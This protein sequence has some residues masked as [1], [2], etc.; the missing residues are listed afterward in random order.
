VALSSRMTNTLRALDLFAGTGW[1]VAAQRLGIEEYGVEIMPE[2]VATREAAGMMTAYRDVWDGLADPTLIPEHDLLIASPPCQTFSMAGKGSGRRAL[3]D[4]LALIASGAWLRDGTA[5]RDAAR[6][7]GL[8]DRTALVLSPLAYAA[9]TS[10]TYIA[11]EQVPTVLPVWEAVGDVLRELG[12]SVAVGVLSA[13]QYGVPQTRKRA[14]LVARRDSVEAALPTPTHSRYY[15]R[16]PLRLDAGLPR[17]TSM[18]EALRFDDGVAPVGALQGDDPA[19]MRWAWEKPASTIVGSFCPDVVSSPGG[20]G[21]RPTDVSRHRQDRP[22]SI[23]VTAE[24]AGVLQ[25]YPADFP[26]QGSK[27]KRFLQIGNAVPPL[28]AEAVLRTFL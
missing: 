13:E 1:G 4:V 18:A 25:S 17:W 15:A 23:K 20:S 7:A 6:E 10:P 19:A 12:Y 2:A 5:L 9:Q 27:T 14:I 22:G 3:D 26:F 24:Q 21:T 11:L 8:D 28:L 16:D